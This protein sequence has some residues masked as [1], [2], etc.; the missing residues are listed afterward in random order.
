MNDSHIPENNN[1]E[2]PSEIEQAVVDTTVKELQQAKERLSYLMAEFDNYKRRTEKERIVWMDLARKDM[3]VD[4][5][6]VVDNL[7]SALGYH[8]GSSE[9]EEQNLRNGV[10]LIYKSFQKVLAKNKIEEIPIQKTFDPE[11]HEALMTVESSDH[12]S[13]D[14]VTVL[15]KGFTFKGAVIRPAKVSVAQ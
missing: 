10:E 8:R 2:N 13:G 11:K 5:L 12:E 1:T 7:E 3:I 15:E 6:P 14:I 4:F 9:G